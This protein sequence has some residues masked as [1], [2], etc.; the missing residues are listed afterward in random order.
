MSSTTRPSDRSRERE[1]S[2]RTAGSGPMSAHPTDDDQDRTE[3]AA[4]EA[5]VRRR[6][7]G[8]GSAGRR[9][10]RPSSPSC[11]DRL[12]RAMAEQENARRRAQRERDEGGEDSRPR[13]SPGICSRRRT[14][15][16]APSRACPRSRHR[17]SRSG[18]A[19]RRHRGDGARFARSA[20][21]ARHPP[22]RRARASRSI[23]SATRR[24]SRWP[25]ASGRPGIVAAVLQPGYLHHDRLLRPAVVGVTRSEGADNRA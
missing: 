7:Q 4:A 14:I 11:K 13:A 2:Q 15:C 3:G 18:T 19:A 22:D 16:A 12:L 24:C 8:R 23:P 5:I 25:T 20:R 1:P 6:R 10:A 9:A 17:A 21:E